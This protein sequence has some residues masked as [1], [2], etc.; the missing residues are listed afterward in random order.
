MLYT[1][2]GLFYGSTRKTLD[3]LLSEADETAQNLRNVSDYL[4]A[5]KKIGV[6]A[7][8]LPTDI[9]NKIDEA[10]GTIKNVSTVVS[11]TTD[12]TAEKTDQVLHYM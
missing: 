5:V 11:D 3:Y 12:T 10:V 7:I 6:D 2:Q 4:S 9:Q 8:V 1:G